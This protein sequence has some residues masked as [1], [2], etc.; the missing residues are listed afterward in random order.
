MPAA[1]VGSGQTPERTGPD[2]HEEGQGHLDG[3]GSDRLFEQV[4]DRCL[5]FQLAGPILPHVLDPRRAQ[6]LVVLRHAVRIRLLTWSKAGGPWT[7]QRMP[8]VLVEW[9]GPQ[10]LLLEGS[11]GTGTFG[12]QGP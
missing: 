5:P 9:C 10:M 11:G 8:G 4:V 7:P 12:I 6:Q 2:L 3:C 1:G